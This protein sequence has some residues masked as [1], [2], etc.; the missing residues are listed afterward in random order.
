MGQFD[1]SGNPVGSSDFEAIV[2]PATGQIVYQYKT[3]P[4][5]NGLSAS[6]GTQ[7]NNGGSVLSI[8]CNSASVAASQAICVLP[9]SVTPPSAWTKTEPVAFQPVVARN[10][11]GQPHTPRTRPTAPG[12]A[13]NPSAAGRAGRE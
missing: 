2:Y 6:I 5:D 13:R 1:N 10:P 8:G 11:A 12:A 9:P 4:A 7:S 3:P